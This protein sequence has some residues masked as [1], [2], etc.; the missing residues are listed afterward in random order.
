MRTLIIASLLFGICRPA[1]ANKPCI[2]PTR[3]E[4]A[5]AWVADAVADIYRLELDEHGDGFLVSASSFSNSPHQTYEVSLAKLDS[6]R[7]EFRVTPIS[8]LET[9][10]Y[11]RGTTCRGSLYLEVGS[12]APKWKTELEFKLLE[13]LLERIRA[14][15]ETVQHLKAGAKR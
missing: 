11:V 8:S 13:P 14:T 4:L 9:T 15:S 3:S 12:R 10:L 1:W 6:H 5:G 2:A 7:I